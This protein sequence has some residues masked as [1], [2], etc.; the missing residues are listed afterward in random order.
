MKQFILVQSLGVSRWT[1]REGE[2]ETDHV[3]FGNDAVEQA[4]YDEDGERV[5]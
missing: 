1:G 4:R 5:G 2:D 3:G